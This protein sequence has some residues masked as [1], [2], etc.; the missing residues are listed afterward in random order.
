[1]PPCLL[2]PGAAAGAQRYR[3]RTEGLFARIERHRTAEDDYWRVRTKDGLVSLYGTPGSAGGD[4][5]ASLASRSGT[6][7]SSWPTCSV[8]A[9]RIWWS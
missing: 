1:M 8:A 2:V 3:P 6:R 5:P 7:R 4:D 9:C